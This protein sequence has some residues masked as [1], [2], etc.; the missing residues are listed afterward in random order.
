MGEHCCFI[1]FVVHPTTAAVGAALY[2]RLR[3][4]AV[5][6]TLR[7]PF[8]TC[9]VSWRLSRDYNDYVLRNLSRGYSRKDLGL[10]CV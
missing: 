5:L 7:L 2:C 4:R 3:S 8:D 1:G 10:R 6:L 9:R